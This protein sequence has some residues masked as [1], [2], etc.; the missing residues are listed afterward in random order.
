MLLK[1]IQHWIRQKSI[2]A[3]KSKKSIEDILEKSSAL[4]AEGKSREAIDS[5]RS[6]L[7]IN[8]SNVA[9]LNDIGVCLANI[10]DMQEAHR[11]FELAY[12]MDDSYTPAVVNHAKFLVD[13]NRSGEGLEYLK[14][15]RA[16]DPLFSHV[17]AVYAGL[18][19]NNIGDAAQAQYFQLQAWIANFD[20]LRLANCYL[21]YNSYND[22]DERILAAE[23]RFWAETIR[24]IN[25][26]LSASNQKN[27]KST[28]IRIGYWSPDFRSHS[29]RYFFRPLQENHNRENFEI[30]IYHDSPFSDIQTGNIKKSC[31][32]FHP[33]FELT[34]N[35]LSTLLKSHHL[36]IL[37][38]LAGHTSNNRV[39]LLQEHLATVQITALGYPPT[40]GLKTVDA[41]LLDRYLITDDAAHH[42]TEMPLVLPS[43]FW[44]FDPMEEEPAAIAIDPPMAH[45]GYVTFG[46]V[47]NIAKINN[48]ILACWREI[49]RR[50]PRSR[51]LIRAINFN[52]AAA[53]PALRARLQA[54]GL[55]IERVDFRKAEGG[56]AYFESYN[57]ID[58]ILDTF[59][60]NGGTTTCFAVYMGVPVISWAGQSLISRM[61]LSVMSNM[62]APELVV[63][64]A[65]AYVR[66]SVTLSQ[67][68]AYLRRFKQ[69]ARQR[70]RK[71]GLGNG[72]IFAQEF[73]QACIA[74]LAKKSVG[75]LDY[76]SQ[77][78]VLPSEE[79]VRRAYGALVHGQ[80]DAARRIL[81]HCLEHYPNC[82]S[83]HILFANTILGEFRLEQA[84]DYLLKH[85]NIFNDEDKCSALVNVARNQI[86]LGLPDLAHTTVDRLAKF[87]PENIF[88]KYQVQLYQA[89]FSTLT[90]Q[91]N[92]KEKFLPL[93]GKLHCIVPCDDV[94]RFNSICAQLQSVCIPIPGWEI[95]YER[96][97]ERQRINSYRDKSNR[98]DIDILV[99]LQKNIDI[100]QPLFFHKIVSALQKHDVM[101][102]AGATRWTKLDWATD[103]FQHKAAGFMTA[104]TDKPEFI[105]M[106]ILGGSTACL[107][108][109]MV[110]L[111]GGLLAVRQASLSL[112]DWDTDL[113]GAETILEQVWSHAIQCAGGKLAVD[114][115]LGVM[116]RRDIALDKRYWA[117][118]RTKIADD[119]AFD[120]FEMKRPDRAFVS[121]PASCTEQ[122]VAIFD[123]YF[124]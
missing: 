122:A 123:M 69:E 12:S 79:I 20:N 111:D 33:V 82:G 72:Q 78:D 16:L 94:I 19:L 30:F 77:I 21:F 87:T 90:A 103:A 5:F 11:F 52:D 71:T 28:K 76:V 88:D 48:R 4:M 107:Q 116:V 27:K 67:D 7:K 115:N 85:L 8:P 96:C 80:E 89:R 2:T 50:L 40:T 112:A 75:D 49:L 51:M 106:M 43:S 10:G 59:P 118:A 54:A 41:K 46:C 83:A 114:R 104:S 36:D 124:Q 45:N 1:F 56:K 68:V 24:P 102:Y 18:C 35:D 84:T 53:E 58:I 55:P 92:S 108:E 6:Y 86:L 109:E 42:Y 99:I 34:D 66:R 3:N 29:V 64:D 100:Y 105:E 63:S 101:G 38:E 32:E 73:E 91:K 14:N 81:T 121:L 47:G 60:F 23:H 17:D 61:G 98:P 9:A 65:D 70:L 13:Q 97:E 110:V 93:E 25:K 119:M 31:D 113:L 39:D 62:G 120:L 117:N 26:Q 95:F 44:C 37:V 57:D 15:A 74:L 22:I